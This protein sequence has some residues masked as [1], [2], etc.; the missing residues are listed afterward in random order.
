MNKIL[1]EP[2]FKYEKILD[3]NTLDK[4]SMSLNLYVSS[5]LNILTDLKGRKEKYNLHYG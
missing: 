1:N 3:L 2:G 4:K 5:T